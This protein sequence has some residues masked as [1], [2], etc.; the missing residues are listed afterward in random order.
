MAVLDHICLTVLDKIGK[1]MPTTVDL[2]RVFISSPGDV[3]DERNRSEMVIGKLNLIYNKQGRDFRLVPLRWE[4]SA[5]PTMGPTYTQAEITR[6]L[7]EYEI[8]VGILGERFGTPT[9]IAGSGTEEE[10]NDAFNRFTSTPTSLRILFYFKD[11][12]PAH[13]NDPEQYARVTT[14]QHELRKLGSVLYWSYSS[15][16][17]YSWA[18]LIHLAFHM[19]DYGVIWG[20]VEAIKGE[21]PITAGDHPDNISEPQ[22]TDTDFEDEDFLDPD[23]LLGHLQSSTAILNDVAARLEPATADFGERVDTLQNEL[24][25][26]RK[27][28]QRQI[29]AARLGAEAIRYARTLDSEVD[30]F[31]NALHQGFKAIAY[32]TPYWTFIPPAKMNDLRTALVK[33]LALEP[34]L[35]T[36]HSR[37]T[38][39]HSTIPKWPDYLKRA[40]PLVDASMLSTERKLTLAIKYAQEAT[41]ALKPLAERL[42]IK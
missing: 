32:L 25:L 18:L 15:A 30:I 24:S 26:L 23:A 38:D 40:K 22:I 11:V 8:Y 14:F 29:V 39:T 2:I 4:E 33:I 21:E 27:E 10:F 1:I 31:V 35:V 36:L 6:Q 42:D 3:S 28:G 17:V 7:G 41:V 37:V 19:E 16:E 34:Q 12:D 9:P 5:Y 13:V 20:P